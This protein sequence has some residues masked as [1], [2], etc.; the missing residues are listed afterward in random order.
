MDPISDF[1]IRVKNAGYA[2]KK[3]VSVPFSKVKSAIADVLNEKGFLGE[4]SVK[5]KGTKSASLDIE[6]LYEEEGR[7]KINGVSRVSKPSRRIYEKSKNIRG[8]KRGYGLAVFSTSKGIMAHMDAKKE[9]LGGELLF[10]LW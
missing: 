7:P 3:S 2:H 4:V 1:L 5:N 9:N 8:Y 10:T 6:L